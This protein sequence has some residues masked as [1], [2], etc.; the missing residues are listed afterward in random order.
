MFARPGSTFSKLK[1]DLRKAAARTI[2]RPRRRIG[3]FA[4]TPTAREAASYFIYEPVQT[5]S[6]YCDLIS[7][8][9]RQPL[10]ARPYASASANRP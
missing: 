1:A 6:G 5:Q 3:R 4:A 2:P 10:A 9:G 7:A 8:A